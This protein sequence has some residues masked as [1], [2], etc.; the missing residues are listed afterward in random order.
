MPLNVGEYLSAPGVKSPTNFNITNIIYRR[1]PS[2]LNVLLVFECG[3]EN[4]S[5]SVQYGNIVWPQSMGGWY[6][7]RRVRGSVANDQSSSCRLLIIIALITRGR[8]G[9]DPLLHTA[10]II[11]FVCPP[12]PGRAASAYNSSSYV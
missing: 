4:K 6:M 2:S 1:V 5:V 9:L 8:G 7:A 11:C 12:T 3:T 10:S